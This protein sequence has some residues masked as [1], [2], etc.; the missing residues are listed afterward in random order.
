M[1]SELIDENVRQSV[2]KF[3]QDHPYLEEMNFIDL[4][5]TGLSPIVH[6]ILEIGIL[7]VDPSGNITTLNQLIKPMGII[8]AENA[9]IHGIT[10]ALTQDSPSIQDTLPS[11]IEFIGNTPIIGHNVQFDCG[12]LIAQSI[13]QKIS[14]RRN[15]VYDTCLFSRQVAKKTKKHPAN[16]KLTTL[17]QIYIKN[18]ED[19]IAH[20]ALTD[21]LSCLQVFMKLIDTLE[22][23][24]DLHTL[25]FEKSF[26][27]SLVDSSPVLDIGLKMNG[28]CEKD[29]QLLMSA[30]EHSNPIQISYQGG[31]LG[32]QLRPIRPVALLPSQKHLVLHAECLLSKQMKNFKLKQILKV[33]TSEKNYV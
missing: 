9:K 27:Y 16:H 3:W 14:L 15:K 7:K 4:E 21:S 22:D 28:M 19:R 20:R 25:F 23:H 17:T 32:E 6:E 8:S 30:I 12:F 33:T 10:N 11:T 5:T 13:Q 2:K 31:S 18:S 26:L 24:S 29:R 1:Q